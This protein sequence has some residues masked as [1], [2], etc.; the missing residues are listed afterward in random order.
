MPHPSRR[1]W[2]TAFTTLLLIV[3]VVG[4]LF[5]NRISNAQ[6]APSNLVNN[7]GFEMGNLSGWTCSSA[8]SV[9]SGPAHSG[10]FALAAAA[11]NS[12]DAQCTQAVSV[13]AS[14]TYSLSAWVQGNYAYVGVTGTGTNDGNT[15]TPSAASYTQLS[16]QFTTGSSTTS[17]TIY[18]HGW[19][20]QGTVYAD[21]FSVTGPS[22]GPTPT[23]TN[24][25]S[26]TAT[27][28]PSPTATRAPSPSPT[29]T[30]GNLVANPGFETGNL[31]G[32][33]CDAGTAVVVSSPVHS[34]NDAL[35]LNPTSSDNA[36]CTQ[37][38]SVQPN[39]AYTLSAWV[40]GNYAY[41]GAN[42]GSSTWTSSGSYTQLSVSITSGST[43][44]LTIFV[45][46]WYGQGSVYV[47]DVALF[48]PGG[49]PTPT[50]TATPTQ[51]PTPTPT[52][53]P[54][55]CTSCGGNL[56]RH[57]ITG[58]WQ[59][60]TNG[61]TPL[62]LSA[63]NSNYTIIAVAFANA[64]PNNPGGVTFSIDSGLSSALGGYTAS[65]FINDIKTL[66]S[67]G[68]KVIIS[69]G[70]ANGTIT[71]NDATS[72]TNFANSVFSLIQTY[73]FDGVDIDLEN[74]LNPTFMTS[75]LQ[76]LSSKVGSSLIITLAPQTV[77]MQSTSGDY[78]Q[79]A[80]NIKTI[81][82][83]VNMQYYNS[84]SMNGCDGKVYSEGTED[85]LVAL[86]CIQLQ[87]G[88]RPD[89]VGLGL[90]A[91]TSAAGGGYVSPSVVNAALDCLETGTNCGSFKPS[92]TYPGIRG[93][94]DWSIN[95]DAANGYNF[96]NT[97][98]PHLSTLP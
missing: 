87:G 55:P 74:G 64:D 86:A 68:K 69:V 9:V 47:D 21:D 20:G 26:P 94:M 1:L 52:P 80:L 33:T 8:D 45:H 22:G 39:T 10:S 31:Q 57:L 7:P 14:T 15:W 83:I 18:V 34:G 40:Q 30:S 82:T 11:N 81:L 58:Y 73:G 90:P 17:V 23:T 67:Q 54:T 24:T 37:T 35:Q 28:T 53:S 25:P 98:G 44:S 5:F 16:M 32:W 3:T 19:Y 89:Q 4:L 49:P 51:G 66:H 48:G 61:A 62:R 60:F 12:D 84:G 79:L 38:I 29:P 71:V 65:D 46:G 78:F 97:I 92:T 77:D 88:L 91:S 93:A 36:Q 56:P 6:A 50:P 75:A 42:G 63:V 85:F 41:L 27:N 43:T 59:D 95:W 72:A 76:Q 13:Q 2:F 70:G 96:A